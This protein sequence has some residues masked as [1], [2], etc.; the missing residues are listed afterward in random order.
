MRIIYIVSFILLVTG[1]FIKFDI[2]PKTYIL[3]II[4]FIKKAKNK[5]KPTLKER[6]KKANEKKKEGY[7][8]RLINETK[9]IMINN[10]TI[11]SFNKLTLISIV[12]S[13]IGII[14]SLLL[15]NIFML[16]VISILMGLIPFYYVKVQNM[17]Y[18]ND[19]KNEL[20]SA[21][22][23]ITTSYMKYNTTFLKA[24][25]ENI[26]QIKYPLKSSFERYIITTEHINSN[27]RENLLQLKNAVNDAVYREWVDGIMASEEDYNLKATLTNITNKFTDMRILN[28][29]LST[30]MI[31]PLRDYLMMVALTIGSI[32]MYAVFSTQAV[33]DYLNMT[34]GKIQLTVVL[35]IIIILSSKVAKELKP[36]EYR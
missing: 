10:G 30:K 9:E 5:K 7:F 23:N 14:V 33:I 6:I 15:N 25:K 26:D 20:E 19:V 34:I 2:T 12:L 16:P 24:V 35:I 17:L 18:I 36:T 31:T 27:T 4:E 22:S 3:D 11:S 29:E 21:L 1:L 13:I 8:E 32:P 28:N